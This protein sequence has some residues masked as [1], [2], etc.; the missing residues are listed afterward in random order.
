MLKYIFRDSNKTYDRKINKALVYI[1][2]W[3]LPV[4]L[5]LEDTVRTTA[6]NEK[7]TGDTTEYFNRIP[8]HK[9]VGYIKLNEKHNLFRDECDSL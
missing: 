5:M 6:K 4:A 8:L 7:S 1:C 3:I 9:H 2:S